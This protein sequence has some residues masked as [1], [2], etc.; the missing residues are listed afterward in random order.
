MQ[1]SGSEFVDNSMQN[2]QLLFHPE[3]TQLQESN[4]NNDSDSQ[5]AS[6]RSSSDQEKNVNISTVNQ[7]LSNE[8][9]HNQ[10]SN[11]KIQIEINNINQTNQIDT[12]WDFTRELMTVSKNGPIKLD[13]KIV[14][15]KSS[16]SKIDRRI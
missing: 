3:S 13:K 5:Q 4:Q 8:Y 12:N 1:E 2:T 9:A 10:T 14:P 11:D 6:E 7:A 16:E 15:A